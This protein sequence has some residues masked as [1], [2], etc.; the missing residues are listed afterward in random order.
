MAIKMA[1]RYGRRKKEKY[2]G[3]AATCGEDDI[4]GSRRRGA[5]RKEAPLETGL[6]KITICAS[7]FAD[8][9]QMAL[10]IYLR[11]VEGAAVSDFFDVERD[12]HINGEYFVRWFLKAGNDIRQE[13]LRTKT[14]EQY[15]EMAALR[16]KQREEVSRRDK[17]NKD[18]IAVDFSPSD[19]AEALSVLGKV[20]LS[21][22][23]QRTGRESAKRD[24]ACALAPDSLRLQLIRSFGIQLTDRQFAA[25]FRVMDIN[26][27]GAK[28]H[29]QHEVNCR[30][31]ARNLK[32]DKLPP[33]TPIL[34]R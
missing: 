3:A 1:R 23:D 10:H 34:G 2:G 17:A 19:R 11:P 8:Q 6:A 31:R 20:A 28:E 30:A 5:R 29:R 33:L 27:D 4:V 25:L 13:R 18:A 16:A 32:L 21:Y 12:G 22:H 24:F 7:S 9:L 26:G 14:A 15:E